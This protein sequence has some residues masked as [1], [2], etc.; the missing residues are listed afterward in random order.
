MRYQNI[1][2]WL[3]GIGSL[4][5][6]LI[7][8]CVTLS[9]IQKGAAAFSLRSY[10][11]IFALFLIWVY[12]LIRAAKIQ[13][14][15][16]R[17]F[18][19]THYVGIISSAVLVAIVFL[20]VPIGYKVLSDETNLVGVS[21]TMVDNRYV[22]LIQNARWTKER[23]IPLFPVLSPKR[24]LLFPFFLHFLHFIFGYH[25]ENVFVLNALVLFGLLLGTFIFTRKILNV[26]AAIA[27]QVLIVS[28]PLVTIYATSG[29]F[30][31]FAALFFMLAAWTVYSFMKEP[32]A[33]G[34]LFV[35]IHCLLLANTRYE[36][37]VYGMIIGVALIALKFVKVPYLKKYWHIYS[38]TPI[39]V[40]PFLFQRL[41]MNDFFRHPRGFVVFSESNLKTHGV[42]LASSFLTFGELPLN[43]LINLVS[44]AL[45]LILIFN[46]CV[47]RKRFEEKFKNQFAILILVC[48]AANLIV[49]LSHNAGSVFRPS[50]IRYFSFI[51]V[52]LSLI[53]AVY[54]GLTGRLSAQWIGGFA[55]L[56]FLLFHPMA[57]NDRMSNSLLETRK[58]NIVYDFLKNYDKKRTLIVT[59]RA[60]IYIVD[61]YSAINFVYARAN[62]PSIRNW[63]ESGEYDKILVIQD[64]HTKSGN[65]LRHNKG[66]NGFVLKRLR[67][68]PN[69]E[70]TI[71]ISQ[72]MFRRELPG[73][74]PGNP[75]N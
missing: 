5:I 23:F 74:R 45:L 24:P 47:K 27:T 51:S 34:L 64:F 46:A 22:A 41:Y 32:S 71:R 36:C 59:H 4:V 70:A 55:L 49:F 8:Y 50:G 73:F 25:P 68:I 15:S 63:Y 52:F 31:L 72:A 29:G 60:C 44:I 11:V 39:L 17:N 30:E 18:I 35:W 67:D 53:P 14:F 61:R 65:P 26:T 58:T 54:I 57:M 69:G 75:V 48:V 21:Q 12:L 33:E 66:L 62:A 28:Q 37:I 56:N 38:L 1:I 19:R 9:N 6:A 2:R 7:L 42:Q 3:L 40:L 20:S 10:Y 43:N 16:I 13:K